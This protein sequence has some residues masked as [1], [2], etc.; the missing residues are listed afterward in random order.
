MIEYPTEN[1]F[2]IDKLRFERYFAVIQADIRQGYLKLFKMAPKMGPKL[3]ARCY[4]VRV[5]RD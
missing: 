4:Q 2:S 5:P 1:T 3:F